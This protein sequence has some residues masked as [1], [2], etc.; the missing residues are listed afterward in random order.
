MK[1]ILE[2]TKYMMREMLYIVLLEIHDMIIYQDTI[3]SMIQIYS[4]RYQVSLYYMV[5]QFLNH[6]LLPEKGT[7]ISRT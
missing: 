1:K 5:L 4:I 2:G 3:Y 6:F 7:L